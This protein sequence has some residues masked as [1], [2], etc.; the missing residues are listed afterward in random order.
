MLLKANG[1]SGIAPSLW[2]MALFRIAIIALA[3]F[4]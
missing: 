4:V 1:W 3:T 2:P